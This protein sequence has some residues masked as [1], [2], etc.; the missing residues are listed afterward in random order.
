M[1]ARGISSSWEMCIPKDRRFGHKWEELR[2]K[3]NNETAF[4]IDLYTRSAAIWLYQ[5]IGISRDIL[6]WKYSQYGNTYVHGPDPTHEHILT[7][8]A[9]EHMLMG[10]AHEHMLVGPAHDHFEFSLNLTNSRCTVQ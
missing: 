4:E 6:I 3:C 2:K 7:G 8:P 5:D 9:H 1:M 10:P